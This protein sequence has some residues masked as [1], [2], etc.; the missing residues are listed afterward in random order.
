MPEKVQEKMSFGTKIYGVLVVF[1]A[2]FHIVAG[3]AFFFGLI[4]SK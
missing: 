4:M 2:I 3:L 1:A